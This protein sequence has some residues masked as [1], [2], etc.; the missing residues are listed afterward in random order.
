[1]SDMPRFGALRLHRSLSKLSA[2][3]AILVL[4]SA[5]P[6]HAQT[7]QS[8]PEDALFKQMASLDAQ[9]FDAYNTCSLETF[10]SFFA[11]D[12][13]FY[14]DKGGLMRGRQA[15]VDA[16]KNNICGKTRRDLVPGTLEVHA[17]DNFGALQIG[18]ARFCDAKQ[19]HCD[20]KTGG[21]GKFIHLWQ[22]TGGAWKITRVISYDHA[23]AGK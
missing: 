17:M 14:H 23:S 7:R 9:V 19:K 21:V 6:I 22:N 10:A 11:E 16:V 13:E 2:L 3:L 5:G 20:G 18:M 4:Q 8:A 1:M 12:V 15:L